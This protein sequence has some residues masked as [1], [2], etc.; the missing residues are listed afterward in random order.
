M[1]TVVGFDRIFQ[2]VIV[3]WEGSASNMRVL[4]WSMDHGDFVVPAGKE[5]FNLNYFSTN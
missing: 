1:M 4:R 3:G 2:F 5:I